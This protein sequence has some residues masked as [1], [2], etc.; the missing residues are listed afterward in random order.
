MPADVEL[1]IGVYT[2]Y[3]TQ[4]AEQAALAE[5]FAAVTL[6]TQPAAGP[7]VPVRSMELQ[8]LQRDDGAADTFRSPQ[9]YRV[10]VRSTGGLA[11]WK[12]SS[13]KTHANLSL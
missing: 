7:Q 12:R 10:L 4:N 6:A 8:G 13:T 3:S 11:T 1:P 2:V 9:W 5:R